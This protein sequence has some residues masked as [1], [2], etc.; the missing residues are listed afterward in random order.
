MDKRIYYDHFDEFFKKLL[1]KEEQSE[2]L[3]LEQEIKSIIE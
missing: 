1:G 3:K 2:L